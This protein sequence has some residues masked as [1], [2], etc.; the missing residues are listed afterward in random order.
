MAVNDFTPINT[1]TDSPMFAPIQSWERGRKRRGVG[2]SRQTTTAPEARVIATEP[3]AERM[4]RS[5]TAQALGAEPAFAAAPPY[6]TSRSARKTSAA[7][8]AIAA[9]ILA[10]GGLAAAGWY[11][12]QPHQ[13]GVAQLT[14]GQSVT[15]TTTAPVA[16]ASNEP[17]AP[18]AVATTVE[19]PAA[20]TTQTTTHVSS[21][22]RAPVRARPPA[23]RSVGDAG[24]NASATLP[25]GPQPYSGSATAP[26]MANPAP[27]PVQVAPPPTTVESAPAPVIATPPMSA[28]DTTA[29]N[30]PATD[31]TKPLQ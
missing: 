12:S 7:P 29:V 10:L 27:T 14:P 26:A 20:T 16:V 8:L 28:P 19:T 9:G 30:P 2:S 22:D 21:A 25:G 24:V 1:T 3:A 13:Q 17:A 23:A 15:T 31:T 4:D 5:D 18:Q 11:A 6:A